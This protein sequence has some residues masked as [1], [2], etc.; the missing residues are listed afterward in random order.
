MSD[1][2][3]LI[4][5]S[6]EARR[7]GD[8]AAARKLANDA[9]EMSRTSHDPHG[10]GAALATLGRL[11]RD[12]HDHRAALASYEEA[13]ELAR[14]CGDELALAQ[15]LR[16]IG[17]LLTEQGELSR[18]EQ[19]YD[20]AGRVFDRL[21]IGQLGQANFHRSIALLREKQGAVGAA[22]DLWVKA[23]AL[24]AATG[25]DAGVQESDRRLANLK[26]A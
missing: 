4:D 14:Q 17:D 19:C 3:S 12:D 21:G 22:A 2:L 9:A 26:T 15:R 6:S 5:R 1:A 23:R 20:E 7:N 25:I 18:A 16:H 13:A 24:Y 10:L 11:H 8:R